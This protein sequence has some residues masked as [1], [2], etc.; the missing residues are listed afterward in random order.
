MSDTIDE[1]DRANITAVTG[2]TAPEGGTTTALP[3]QTALIRRRGTRTGE[4]PDYPSEMQA[5]LATPVT[6]TH[7]SPLTENLIDVTPDFHPTCG[8]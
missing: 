6:G 3:A 2:Y 7:R 1:Q 4:R 5:L 8:S